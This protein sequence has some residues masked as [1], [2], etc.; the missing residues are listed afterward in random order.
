MEEIIVVHKRRG[1]QRS[2]T[3]KFRQEISVDLPH[4]HEKKICIISLKVDLCTRALVSKRRITSL[5]YVFTF[6]RSGIFFSLFK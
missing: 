4:I 3:F 1:L 2:T 6:L 5:Y